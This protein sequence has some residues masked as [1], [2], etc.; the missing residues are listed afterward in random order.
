LELAKILSEK[1]LLDLVK[2]HPPRN[3]VVFRGENY[4]FEEGTLS[5]KGNTDRIHAGIVETEKKYGQ[6]ATRILKA[7]AEKGGKFG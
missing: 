7:M 1:R 6:A 5:L 2:K 3:Y 4:T